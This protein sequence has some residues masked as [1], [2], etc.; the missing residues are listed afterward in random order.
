MA[1]LSKVASTSYVVTPIEVMKHIVA[2]ELKIKPEEVDVGEFPEFMPI[3]DFKELHDKHRKRV[4]RLIKEAVANEYENGVLPVHIIAYAYGMNTKNVYGAIRACGVEARKTCDAL[5]DR[6][7]RRAELYGQHNDHLAQLRRNHPMNEGQELAV[8]RGGLTAPAMMEAAEMDAS[9]VI[10]SHRKILGRLRGIAS[11]MIEKMETP[12]RYGMTECDLNE[13][14]KI[15]TSG[16][17]RLIL[18]E[19]Q[20]HGLDSGI[21]DET[22]PARFEIVFNNMADGKMQSASVRQQQIIDVDAEEDCKEMSIPE[23]QFGRQT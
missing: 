13:R 16:L 10:T 18:L 17:A 2:D 3:E 7:S 20:A 5:K 21:H 14:F 23:V 4:Q 9:D 12:H 19:R 8:D 11:R 1:D 6:V 22:E 15:V